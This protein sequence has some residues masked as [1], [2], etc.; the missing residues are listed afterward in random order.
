[1]EATDGGVPNRSRTRSRSSGILKINT[2][3][4]LGGNSNQ[5]TLKRRTFVRG[6]VITSEEAERNFRERSRTEFKPEDCIKL[7]SFKSSRNN[8]KIIDQYEN[9]IKYYKLD[10]VSS[11][12]LLNLK[13][14]ARFSEPKKIKLCKI[15]VKNQSTNELSLFCIEEELYVKM[16]KFDK[17]LITKSEM[18]HN[19]Y[20]RLFQAVKQLP[21][22]SNY[23][24]ELESIREDDDFEIDDDDRG[25]E[26]LG[27]F[28]KEKLFSYITRKEYILKE[29]YIIK[30]PKIKNRSN[31]DKINPPDLIDKFWK[32]NI[33]SNIEDDEFLCDLKDYSIDIIISSIKFLLDEISNL[34][35][36]N[37]LR[38]KLFSFYKKLQSVDP[39]NAKYN[40]EC[41]K[42]CTALELYSEGWEY[43]QKCDIKLY[44]IEDDI[45]WLKQLKNYYLHYI[46]KIFNNDNIGEKYLELA[47][48]TEKISKFNNDEDQTMILEATDHF[49]EGLI[50][51]YNKNKDL[52]NNIKLVDETIVGLISCSA[53][54]RSIIEPHNE[55][56]LLSISYS[57]LDKISEIKDDYI[58]YCYTQIVNVNLIL[59]NK[60]NSE[61]NILFRITIIE[62]FITF[63]KS[64]DLNKLNVIYIFLFHLYSSINNNS[65]CHKYS[66]NILELF[67]NELLNPSKFINVE[68]KKEKILI[69]ID[70]LIKNEHN[71]NIYLLFLAYLKDN[72]LWIMNNNYVCK[73][74]KLITDITEPERSQLI[75][76]SINYREEYEKYKLKL[77]N[78]LVFVVDTIVGNKDSSAFINNWVNE[79]KILTMEQYSLLCTDKVTIKLLRD[80][81]SYNNFNDLEK[82]EYITKLYKY[83]GMG[84]NNNFNPDKFNDFIVEKKRLVVTR[85]NG[86]QV[87]PKTV[88][89]IK[90]SYLL[91]KSPEDL[92]IFYG[93][94][95]N[96]IEKI[97]DK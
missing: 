55:K 65:F 70:T 75:N 49:L 1:M 38:T 13:F 40:Y 60:F 61:D 77:F 64:C 30:W 71:T 35:Q 52:G 31:I 20:K 95:L 43:L 6:P 84:Y 32:Y 33:S 2:N 96:I 3:S 8:K 72:E 91:G 67:V 37:Y 51:I 74:S 63:F 53:Y 79:S 45:I 5:K 57:C 90:K 80:N 69:I 92:V 41:A 62:K 15:E 86:D 85:N 58:D 17:F 73:F 18:E 83:F 47:L 42:Y 44:F 25:G 68:N 50:H 28:D 24:K 48:F 81:I 9:M 39:T 26:I 10:S 34:D 87:N 19:S 11:M 46:M 27:L 97:I 21:K 78:S 56:C 93:V 22:K 4:E 59:Q 88:E 36:K 82:K 23:S 54:C 16:S 76:D 94:S 14:Y 89:A 66:D 29:K 12:E 7:Q